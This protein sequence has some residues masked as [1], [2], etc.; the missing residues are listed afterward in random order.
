MPTLKLTVPVQTGRVGQA[1]L[2]ARVR[3]RRLPRAGREESAWQLSRS[4]GT[5]QTRIKGNRGSWSPKTSREAAAYS[6]YGTIASRRHVLGPRWAGYKYHFP[7]RCIGNNI[8]NP[9]P[10]KSKAS[11]A[12]SRSSITYRHRRAAR[13]HGC[14]QYTKSVTFDYDHRNSVDDITYRRNLHRL[15]PSR[16]G[17]A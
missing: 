11:A 9:S 1:T 8:E 5:R 14:V 4:N 6:D 12:A 13:Q 15:P 7:V 3:R 10:T 2:G 17:R 16:R